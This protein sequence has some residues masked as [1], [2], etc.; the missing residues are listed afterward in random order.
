MRTNCSDI[1]Q[2]LSLLV[3]GELPGDQAKTVLAHLES[4]PPCARLRARFEHQGE[5][6]RTLPVPSLGADELRLM[7]L[8]ARTA[9]G[10]FG[11]RERA[12]RNVVIRATGGS[13]AAT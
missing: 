7:A 3:A 10:S 8:R 12:G 5:L 4:C 9:Q 1:E 2:A 11:W 6:L 13:T